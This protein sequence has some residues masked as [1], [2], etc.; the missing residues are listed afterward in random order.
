MPVDD[1]AAGRWPPVYDAEDL[2]AEIRRLVGRRDLTTGFYDWCVARSS[3]TL[4][5]IC[6]GDVLRLASDLPVIDQDGFPNA[7][8]HPSERWL[9]I[10][11]TCDFARA[12]SQVRWTQLVPIHAAG[13]TSLAS[14]KLQAMTSYTST[15]RFYLPTWGADLEAIHYLAD[16]TSPIGADKLGLKENAMVEARMSRG[17]WVL[18]NSCL[19]RF[20]AR[21]DGRYEE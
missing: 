20:L 3:R 1:A 5:D 16:F 17:A 11:N 12:A 8:E 2:K 7:L 15:R 13:D 19:V 14:N 21:D 18:L 6:Q 10:G 9:V 4:T